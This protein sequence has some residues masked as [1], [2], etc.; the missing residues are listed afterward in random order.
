MGGVVT[1]NVYMLERELKAL[2]EYSASIP[3][4][5]TLGKRWRRRVRNGWWLGCYYEGPDVPEGSV[6]IAWLQVQVVDID[7]AR[8]RWL[9]TWTGKGD[10][11]VRP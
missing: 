5:T 10:P 11:A 4:G 3:T 6:G 2:P 7:C 9:D 8:S 1:R